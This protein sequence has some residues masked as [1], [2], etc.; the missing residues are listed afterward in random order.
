ML[1]YRK[2]FLRNFFLLENESQQVPSDQFAPVSHEMLE[3]SYG[4]LVEARMRSCKPCHFEILNLKNLLETSVFI[5]DTSKPLKCLTGSQ[6]SM[7]GVILPFMH[8]YISI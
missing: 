2:V 7:Y 3:V 8:L 5:N 4:K 1:Q 6:S